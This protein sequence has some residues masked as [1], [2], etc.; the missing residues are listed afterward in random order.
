M[1]TYLIIYIINFLYINLIY[2]YMN[3]NTDFYKQKYFK[4]KKK[5]LKYKQLGGITD[6]N[7]EELETHYDNYLTSVNFDKTNN[8]ELKDKIIQK[9]FYDNKTY[10]FQDINTELTKVI[11][12]MIKSD[13]KN[14]WI[15]CKSECE[16]Y[17][18]KMM[19]VEIYST[20]YM[21]RL[22]S[23]SV[24]GDTDNYKIVFII[25]Q[26]NVLNL[27]G[28]WENDSQYFDI[29]I[30]D[31][32][33]K[34]INNRNNTGRLI[35]GFGPSAS[36]KTYCAKQIIEL[37]T[38]VD[39]TFP[40]FFLTIDGGIY[41]EQSH[42]YQ[43]IVKICKQNN[44][45]GLSN[46]VSASV[47]TTLKTIFDS[48]IIKK[49]MKKFLLSQKNKNNQKINLYVPD[50]ITAC[51]ISC[52]SLYQDYIDI[53]GDTDWIGLM[54]YQHRSGKECPYPEQYKCVGCKESGES[55]EINEGK[56]YSS[57]AWPNSYRNGN[58]SILQASNY[59][60]RIHNSGG[61][62]TNGKI[63]TT[64]FEDLSVKPI[65]SAE[66]SKFLEGLHWKYSQGKVKNDNTFFKPSNSNAVVPISLVSLV[67]PVPISVR[68]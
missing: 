19:S 61:K 11:Q 17:C 27:T 23:T 38:K 55:R 34:E 43:K 3:S 9:S 32:N 30:T 47:L 24:I 52:K 29:K 10:Y 2:I 51:I 5:Y 42:I 64:I 12:K 46:L 1:F 7:A 60:F 28:K 56:K 53:T 62:K 31:S 40:K 13:D 37:M 20:A 41:R 57:T 15:K 26:E 14:K 49:N 45:A 63:N 44:I 59:K 48:S 21:L 39:S 65:I 25:R 22:L 4:Y 6:L 36:G 58:D 8:D 68:T 35:M 67:S 16:I 50:T 18:L 66:T 33:K 54:I